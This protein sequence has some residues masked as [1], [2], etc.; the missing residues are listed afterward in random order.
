[1]LHFGVTSL[2]SKKAR[3]QER[4]APLRIENT[5]HAEVISAILRT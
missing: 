4:K 3:D 2:T 5:K 1:M